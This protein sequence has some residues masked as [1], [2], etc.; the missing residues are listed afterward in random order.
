V[1]AG[2]ATFDNVASLDESPVGLT[3][4][5]RPAREVGE[6]VGQGGQTEGARSGWWAPLTECSPSARPGG[7]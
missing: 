1:V 7:R 5:D 3:A 4:V 6:V 2:A